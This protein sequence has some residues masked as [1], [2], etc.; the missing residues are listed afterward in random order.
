MIPEVKIRQTDVNKLI[1]QFYI[2]QTSTGNHFDQ[3]VNYVPSNNLMPTPAV[4][5]TAQDLTSEYY[6]VYTIQQWINMLNTTLK[7]C[8]TAMG[9]DPASFYYNIDTALLKLYVPASWGTAYKLYC[10]KQLQTLLDSFEFKYVNTNT[11]PTVTYGD[12]YEF[13][14]Y[15]NN[16]KNNETVNSIAYWVMNQES[17][18]TCLL[19]PVSSIV[20]TT[21]LFPI[22]PSLL[23]PPKVF[24]AD[25]SLFNNGNN[26]NIA[27]V[28]T[29]FEVGL[30]ATNTYKEMIEYTPTAEYRLI[31]MYGNSPVSTIE[32]SVYW[33]D[34]FNNLHFFKLNSGCSCNVK[35]MFRRKD[36]N[37]G[38]S[39]L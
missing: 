37:A 39:S 35:I 25:A 29:D 26:S 10:N 21:G 32:L 28:I 30:S 24:G 34:K 8:S 20:F 4:P 6:F 27:P 3:N 16:F 22:Q 17:S 14:F 13:Q 7:N 15:N 19:N 36:F 9:L 38:L 18:T 2:I 31:D 1:Y 33:K 11:Y 5:L 23:S 12:L